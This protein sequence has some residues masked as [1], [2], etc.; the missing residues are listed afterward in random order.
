MKCLYCWVEQYFHIFCI[1]YNLESWNSCF[2]LLVLHTAHFISLFIIHMMIHWRSPYEK[3]I[4]LSLLRNAPS[5]EVKSTVTKVRNFYLRIVLFLRSRKVREFFKHISEFTISTKE[6]SFRMNSFSSLE[7]MLNVDIHLKIS[8]IHYECFILTHSAACRWQHSFTKR[9]TDHIERDG[10][11]IKI[12]FSY[13][14]SIYTSCP[15][16]V[17]LP[18]LSP[19]KFK[20]GFVVTW[21]SIFVL[22]FESLLNRTLDHF[23]I[24]YLEQHQQQQQQ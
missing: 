8:F 13:T 18:L 9:N 15:S 16:F 1:I 10:W 21:F 5:N 4:M 12:V 3:W 22:F 23:S 2:E 6:V 7:L 24:T 11:E 17:D 20:L 19:F 14:L